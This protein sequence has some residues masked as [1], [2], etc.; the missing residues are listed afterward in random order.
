MNQPIKQMVIFINN[1][2]FHGIIEHLQNNVMNLL[3]EYDQNTV[4]NIIR[5]FED[6]NTLLIREGD[7]VHYYTMHSSKK[8][9]DGR[10]KSV[11]VYAHVDLT[12]GL[13]LLRIEISYTHSETIDTIIITENSAN[14]NETRVYDYIGRKLH[15]ITTNLDTKETKIHTVEMS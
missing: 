13:Y 8:H 12:F 14:E 4:K 9:T 2:D 6:K 1:F 10:L 15:S 11:N 3:D 7:Y 5:A